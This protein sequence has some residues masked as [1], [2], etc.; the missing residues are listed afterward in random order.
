MTITDPGLI[1]W[2]ER[3]YLSQFSRLPLTFSIYIGGV[4]ADPDGS[5]VAGQLLMENPDGSATVVSSYSATRDEPGVYTI[6]PS[7]SDTQSPGYAELDW[8]YAV[9]G[10]PQHYASYLEIGPASPAYDALPTEMQDFLNDQVWV[11]FA[12]LF[13]SAGGGPNLQSQYQ[14]H[15]SRGRVA[16]LMGIALQKINAAAQPW[17]NY[18]LD[19]NGGAQYPVQFWGGLLASYAYVEGV[20]QLIRAYTEQPSFM[21]PPVARQDRRDYADRWRAVLKD[22]EAEL[23]GLLD[24]FKIRHLLNGSP[25]V[26]VSGG[27]Y[28][29]YAPTRIA[30]SVAARPRMFAR[31]Y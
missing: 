11:R 1:D 2:K 15:W 23:K 31:W 4:L 12:D 25:R 13:D 22:E 14:A 24:V 20:K 8:S 28:G 9:G 19:G 30:G 16:Q 21:G 7:S 26:L 3:S 29:R 6:T 18:T 10:Q 27:A 5:A 17:S